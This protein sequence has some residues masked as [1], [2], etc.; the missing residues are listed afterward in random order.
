MLDMPLVQRDKEKMQ[1]SLGKTLRGIWQLR[2]RNMG[3]EP[4]QAEKVWKVE[5][6]VGCQVKIILLRLPESQKLY[7][8]KC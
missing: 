7:S 8:V 3:C 5:R 1:L 6:C 4:E 2:L